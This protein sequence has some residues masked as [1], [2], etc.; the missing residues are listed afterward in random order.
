MRA[1]RRLLG[2]TKIN[3]SYDGAFV[4][5]FVEFF[6]NC[7]ADD[8][9]V[10]KKSLLTAPLKNNSAGQSLIAN[11]I[12]L[13][14]LTSGISEALR[15]NSNA[16]LD[17]YLR[18]LEGIKTGLL[19]EIEETKEIETERKDK[20]KTVTHEA[21]TILENVRDGKP[22]I[23]NNGIQFNSAEELKNIIFLQDNGNYYFGSATKVEE[24]IKYHGKGTYT[25]TN[26]DVYEGEFKDGKRD[27]KG[28]FKYANGDV[29]EGG[30]KDGKKDGEGIYKYANGDVYEGGFQDGEKDGEGI[31][32]YANGDVYKGGYKNGKRN[33]KSIF[34]YANGDVYEGGFQD[35]EKDGKGI[36]KD[37]LK[38]LPPISKNH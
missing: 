36:F 28:I 34:K 19:K 18:N 4:E 30:F 8:A 25:N 6:T 12:K 1:I 5:G 31:F 21:F 7:F 35:G 29:Y 32:K 3:K 16:I 14:R 26:G 27:G 11:S 9:L 17:I 2:E 15:T 24:F 38:N 23:F 33:G 13:N 20:L 37:T 10:F 22:K